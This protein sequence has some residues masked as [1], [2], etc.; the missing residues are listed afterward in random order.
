[1]LLDCSP[2]EEVENHPRFDE[3]CA[4]HTDKAQAIL[5]R[6]TDAVQVL[7]Y[8]LVKLKTLSR[9]KAIEIIRSPLAHLAD[10]QKINP[11]VAEA[12]TCVRSNGEL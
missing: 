7:A 6:E 5:V 4:R 1:V 3:M 9:S 11:T 2:D 12:R 8:A 10:L